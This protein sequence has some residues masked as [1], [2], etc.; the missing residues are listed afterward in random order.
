[1]ASNLLFL[2]NILP[3]SDERKQTYIEF[4]ESQIN[5]IVDDNPLNINY[6]VG[7]EDNSLK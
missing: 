2:A 4:G 1:M 5:Y 6:V 3:D 7:A